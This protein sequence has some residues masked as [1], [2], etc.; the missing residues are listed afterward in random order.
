M[1]SQPRNR[2]LLALIIVGCLLGTAACGGSSGGGGS[3]S[4]SVSAPADP[5]KRAAELVRGMSDEQLVGQV[6]MPVAY[7]YDATNVSDEAAAHNRN[8]DGADT[9]AQIVRKYHLGGLM[10]VNQGGGPDPTAETNPTSNIATPKQVR[11]LTGGLQSAALGESGGLPMLVATDQEFGV[12]TRIGTGVSALPTGLGLGAAHDPALT[13]R[14]WGMAG[15]E[16]AALGVNVD[17]APDADVLGGPGNAVIGSRS[18]GSDPQ[19]VATQTAAAVAGLQGAGV[20]ATPKHFPGHG[21]TTTDSHQA[22]PVLRQSRQNLDANDLRPFRSAIDADSWM[23]MAGHLDVRALDP[24]VPAT[25]SHTVLHDVLRDQ[26]HFKG[27]VVSD[28]L[29]MAPVT[30]RYDGGE[31][32]VH[33]LKAGNDLLLEPP[34]LAAAQHGL[35]HG[36]KSGE[37]SRSRLVEAATRVLT[38]RGRLAAFHQPPLSDVHGGEHRATAAAAASAAVTTMRGVCSGPLVH[39]PVAL[40]GGTRE[41]REWLAAGL[42]ADGVTVSDDA[43]TQVALTGYGDTA[44]D[45]SPDADV[46]VGMDEPYLLSQVHSGTVLASFGATHESMT[47]VAHVLSGKAKATGRSPVPVDGLP[48]SACA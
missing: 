14:S 30:D 17:F 39:G 29:N 43:P 47:A 15:G 11:K 48:A 2:I 1:L 16:L 44:A 21:H 27:V 40:T 18:F 24:G 25:L 7:G 32:A 46:T 45:L 31:A 20:A 42:K 12:V 33:A 5:A 13:R 4:P 36:L 38:L 10:L 22:L 41:K 19:A 26:L 8:L 37:L 9:P 3:A 34:N 28:A 23:V 6:L 35:L